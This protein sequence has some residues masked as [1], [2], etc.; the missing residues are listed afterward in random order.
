[1]LDGE[2]SDHQK[3]RFYF[4]D[5]DDWLGPD[6]QHHTKN[7]AKAELFN[8]GEWLAWGKEQGYEFQPLPPDEEMKRAGCIMLPG[9]EDA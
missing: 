9:L 4:S 7:K 6:R 3:G 5:F 1:M 8:Y 2:Y